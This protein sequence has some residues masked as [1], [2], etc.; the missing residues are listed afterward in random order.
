[1]TTRNVIS[2]PSIGALR[3]VYSITSSARASKMRGLSGPIAA[4]SK[5]YSITSKNERNPARHSVA[6]GQLCLIA[7]A[8]VFHRLRLRCRESLADF[9]GAARGLER[10]VRVALELR[11]HLSR[12]Q[13]VAA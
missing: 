6:R 10:T 3:Y 11:H 7:R 9:L 8:R 4:A 1:M 12:N 5:P 2:L 13:F